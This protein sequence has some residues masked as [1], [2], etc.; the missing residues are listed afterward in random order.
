MV[1]VAEDRGGMCVCYA[2]HTPCCECHRGF[3]DPPRSL[4]C[5]VGQALPEWDQPSVLLVEQKIYQSFRAHVVAT[6]PSRSDIKRRARHIPTVGIGG[7][8]WEHFSGTS[9]GKRD[10]VSLIRLLQLYS[11]IKHQ[12][13]AWVVTP[14]GGPCG[15]ARFSEH[16]LF[17]ADCRIDVAVSTSLR[18]TVRADATGH[19]RPPTPCR[20]F[21]RKEQV[22]S[23]TTFDLGK[24]VDA[25]PRHPPALFSEVFCGHSDARPLFSVVGPVR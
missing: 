7:Q 6:D 11:G 20:A 17:R 10:L 8:S 13:P 3:D 14:A 1:D 19:L 2:G 5:F 12:R 16:N 23:A 4:C 24:F 21:Y 22:H 25:V 9:E 18:P 15:T